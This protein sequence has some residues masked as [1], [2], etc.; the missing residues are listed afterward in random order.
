MWNLWFGE[1]A[2]IRKKVAVFGPFF[3][4]WSG[5]YLT[6]FPLIGTGS[7]T[8]FDK[9]SIEKGLSFGTVDCVLQDRHGVMWL[10]TP[11]GLNRFDGYNFHVYKYEPDQDDKLS[12]NRVVSLLEDHRED[13][14]V[15]TF[16][17]LCRLNRQSGEFLVFKANGNGLENDHITTLFETK[18]HQFWVGT[19]SG[20]YLMDRN[21]GAFSRLTFPGEYGQ[22]AD[23][24]TVVIEGREGGLWIGTL[25]AGLFHYQ[26]ETGSWRNWRHNPDDPGS[27]SHNQIQDLALDARGALWVG[28]EAGLDKVHENGSLTPNS[29]DCLSRVQVE[30]LLWNPS[31]FLWVG[32]H[33]SLARVADDGTCQIYRARAD[34]PEGL[35]D[36]YVRCLFRDRDGL[37]WIGTRKGVNIWVPAREHFQAF[38]PDGSNPHGLRSQKVTWLK[39]DRFGNLWIGGEGSGLERRDAQGRYQSFVNQPGNP[40]SLCHNEVTAVVED[41]RGRLWIGTHG[42]LSLFDRET[43]TF[44]SIFQDPTPGRGL[45]H[46]H[47]STVFADDGGNL[48]IGTRSGL[49]RMD[50]ETLE[51][52]SYR[53]LGSPGDYRGL[54]HDTVWIVTQDAAGM[55]WIGTPGG[56]CRL[57]PQ[58]DRFTYFFHD[59][60]DPASLTSDRIGPIVQT[61]TGALWVGT[62]YGLNKLADPT[63]H[64]GAFVRYTERDGLPSNHVE[65]LVEDLQGRLWISGNRGLSCLDPETETFHNYD[66]SDGLQHSEFNSCSA[67]RRTDGQVLFGSMNGFT[68]FYPGRI[69]NGSVS[70]PPLL[71]QIS[72]NNKSLFAGLPSLDR[73]LPE[74]GHRDVTFFFEYSALNFKDPERVKYRFKLEGFDSDWVDNGTRRFRAYTN[75]PP[76]DYVLRVAAETGSGTWS[77][78]SRLSFKVKPAPWRTWWA[79]TIYG[80]AFAGT[81]FWYRQDQ[82]RELLRERK[83]NERLRQVDRLK[84][85]FLANTSH[86][87]RTPLH[88]VIGLTESLLAGVAGSLPQT[89]RAHLDLVLSSSKRLTHLVNDILD[90]SKLKNKGLQLKFQ[91][92]DLHA[93]ADVVISLSRVQ[94]GNRPVELI[95]E[96]GE[97]PPVHADEDR[98]QQILHNLVGNA[99]KFTESGTVTVRANKRGEWM[100]VSVVDTG[101]GIAEKDLE[102][103][104]QSFEQA[105]GSME[106]VKGGTGLGLAITRELVRLHGGKVKA[107]STLG[108]GSTFSFSLPMAKREVRETEPELLEVE[109]GVDLRDFVDGT[110]FQTVDLDRNLES[111]GAHILIVD[112]EP[113]NRQVLMSHLTL[114]NHRVSQAEDGTEA[115]AMLA[116]DDR[117]DLVLLDVMM[118]RL[119]GFEVCQEL[120]KN[121]SVHELPVIFLTARTGQDDLFSGFK[122]GGNDY[123][124][125]PV[126]RV[127]LQS[128]VDLHLKL[129]DISRNLERKVADRTK[130]LQAINKELET[131]DDIVKTINAEVNLDAVLDV[132]LKQGLVLFPEARRGTAM[133]W[134]PFL[135]SFRTIASINI[136]SPEMPATTRL[137]Q[138]SAQLKH[139]KH[140]NRGVYLLKQYP[141]FEQGAL[142]LRLNPR[143]NVQ[144]VLLW[145]HPADVELLRQKG[146]SQLERFRSHVL[147]AVY[148]AR[149]H[150]ELKKR[151][152]AMRDDIA[153]AKHI[154]ASLLPGEEILRANLGDHFVL[155]QPKL[156]VSGDFYWCYR[157]G[158]L[159]FVAVA[160]CTGHGVQGAL[161]AMVGYTLLN[162]VTRDKGEQDPAKVLHQLYQSFHHTLISQ[163]HAHSGAME[164]SFCCINRDKNEVL[165]AGARRSLV[166]TYLGRDGTRK[167]DRIRG[168]RLDIGGHG[169]GGKASFSNRRVPFRPGDVFYLFTD[170]YADQQNTR[171]KKIGSPALRQFLCEISGLE[172]NEQ[173]SRLLL[174]MEQHRAKVQQRDDITI[175]GVRY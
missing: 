158:D 52:R 100:V 3:L 43:E 102:R 153:A 12:D 29:L 175:L 142:V 65:G 160:D 66:V 114:V 30:S 6:A 38:V 74:F 110:I 1:I 125:K 104:F 75:I 24:I 140:L 33:E 90:F 174:W 173:K 37:I 162:E 53:A 35:S 71:T 150:S 27:L 95:N 88:G 73:P 116:G 10:G 64:R 79:Y 151:T 101:V 5:L 112:D 105:D 148:K 56:L 164:M 132:M 149:I 49:D 8:Q 77:E 163:D 119:S 55:L 127:E 165:F 131:L 169:R 137:E 25:T 92:V 94:I 156:L 42:G 21:E 103:I 129:M 14:W 20:L 96:I 93:L 13:L 41:S 16:R 80:L 61:K 23:Q 145:D 115:L 83:V 60:A 134:D 68:G 44:S 117:F 121:F 15:G 109:D 159:Q 166:R 122:A 9:I 85:E 113:V 57:D 89:A 47:I 4:F 46:N 107:N 40:E 111:D 28:T 97:V 70:R 167:V 58:S 106:R 157:R 84:D 98:L 11:Y 143:K 45:S 54:I 108:K 152:K 91:P 124:A 17:G 36:D 76:K 155:F 147:A 69:A 19:Q 82:K 72:V 34:H 161:T 135:H 138:F 168:D 126:T 87:L 128:R 51:T 154:Q 7:E 172:L 146:S 139:G 62:E 48:W 120:R 39:E 18:N 130:H 171:G 31:G 50:L 170:G 81:L 22:T 144:V 99:V 67:A 63:S 86:E 141:G 26:P 32:T 118:P 133:M 78:E 59:P 2:L 123:I 136:N